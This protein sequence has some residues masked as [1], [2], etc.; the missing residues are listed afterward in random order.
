MS[1]EKGKRDG[2]T[3]DLD[4]GEFMVD[5]EREQE[6]GHQKV[7]DLEGLLLLA[8]RLAHHAMLAHV[9]NNGERGG[10]ENDFHECVVAAAMGGRLRSARKLEIWLAGKVSEGGRCGAYKEM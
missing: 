8:V 6:S 2:E 5:D 9:P 1:A 10:D 3:A 4:D 7:D